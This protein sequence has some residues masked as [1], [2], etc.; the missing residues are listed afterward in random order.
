MEKATRNIIMVRYGGVRKLAKVFGVSEAYV[1]KSLRG[2][3]GGDRARKIRHVALTQ[4]DGMEM[5][6]VNNDK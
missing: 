5:E 1:S 6:Q 2:H 4:M 3:A